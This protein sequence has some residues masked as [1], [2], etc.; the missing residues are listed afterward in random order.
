MNGIHPRDKRKWFAVHFGNQYVS[1][2]PL[3]T[4]S[5]VFALAI[6]LL[7]VL[8]VFAFAALHAHVAGPGVA[9]AMAAP[10]AK[11]NELRQQRGELNTQMHALLNKAESEKRKL[12]AEETENWDKMFADDESIK[13]EIGRLERQA[14]IDAE[15]SVH[16]TE[17]RMQDPDSQTEE[18]KVSEFAMCSFKRALLNGQQNLT[19][20]ERR[21]LQMDLA[22]SGGYLVA[23]QMFVNELIMAVRDIV[24]MRK[25]A[26]VRSVPNAISLGAPS[27]ETE[28]SDSTWTAEI[29]TGAA[30]TTMA[31]G[32][33]E[34]F[35]HPLAK[36]I[37]V[38]NKLLRAS[39]QSVDQIVRAA[40]AYKLA[41]P[42]E[43]AYLSGT[44]ANQ[45]LGVFT[46]SALGI[47]VARDVSTGNT[48]TNITPD[49]LINAKYS[50]RPQYLN[51]GNLR[52]IFHRDAI[53]RIRKMKDGDGQYL[54]RPGIANDKGDMILDVPF[55]M[56]EYCPDTWTTGLY[57]GIIGDFSFYWIAD[58]L[59]MTIQ[60][61]DQLYAA[62]NQ[63]G[64]FARVETDGMPV[65]SEAFARVTLA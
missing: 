4:P 65:L 11:I 34:L 29:L 26:T 64:Y 63:T 17:T 23:P 36:S 45:P 51:G 50:L 16:L 3:H 43:R 62:S 56:S 58:A 8:V 41:I 35:P 38:S 10:V 19:E 25:I 53:A 44:G 49:G 33:R 55:I 1:S 61:V 60:V 20:P 32:K 2:P 9:L 6:P 22:D 47:P 37:R 24:Y 5:L 31:F 40:L 7:A 48:T 27:L 42:M 39:A 46:A 12:T 52:W 28:A 13:G 57:V 54:W 15:L 30:D 18:K 59:D 21:A 14:K